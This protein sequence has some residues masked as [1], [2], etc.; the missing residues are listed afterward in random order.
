MR[1]PRVLTLSLLVL[2]GTAGSTLGDPPLPDPGALA[3][4]SAQVQ[5]LHF[6]YG[7]IFIEPGQ[8]LILVG[9]VTIEKPAYDGYMVGF[10]PNLI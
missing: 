6:K 10:R 7:P 1:L 9:P 5:H 3:P 2:A 4:L 8:N